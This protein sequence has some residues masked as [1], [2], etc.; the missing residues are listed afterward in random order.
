M[1]LRNISSISSLCLEVLVRESDAGSFPLLAA[2]L[3][4]VFDATLS[5]AD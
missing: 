2:K 1:R 3:I 4:A 5:K